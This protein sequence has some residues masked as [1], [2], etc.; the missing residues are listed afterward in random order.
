MPPLRGTSRS[1]PV[2][3]GWGTHTP[4]RDHGAVTQPGCCCSRCRGNSRREL[5][6]H[7]QKKPFRWWP[8]DA[9]VPAPAS[10]WD[11]NRGR[12]EW[13]PAAGRPG[14]RPS[15]ADQHLVDRVAEGVV[16]V[17][18]LVLLI[19]DEEARSAVHT[20]PDTAHEILAHPRL[21]GVVREGIDDDG[22]GNA[23]V[24]GVAAEIVVAQ[25]TLVGEDRLMHRPELPRRARRFGGLGS[26]LGVRVDLREREVPEHEAHAVPEVALQR[27]DDR[28]GS[29]AVG[30]LVVAILDE[31]D[32]GVSRAAGVVAVGDRGGE[33]A[34]RASSPDA[35]WSGRR[36]SRGT[37]ADG[38]GT[39]GPWAA[40]PARARA[41]SRDVSRDAPGDPS[42]SRAA[43]MPS[44]PGLTPIGERWLQRITPSPS[45]TK[46]ARSS[47]PSAALYTPYMRATAPLGSKSAR[48]GKC[49]WR[50]AANAAW[51]H[52]PS[53]E[54][55]TS[56]ARCR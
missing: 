21:E 51:H 50:A 43:R 26:T 9:A 16:L 34:H 13:R 17:R 23:G 14:G 7:H 33:R 6:L 29:A 45:T 41:G 4:A 12:H 8:R 24:G 20:A 5:P 22:A 49:K 3:G 19:V 52:A 35:P 39:A 32:R 36:G 27:L 48:S 37:L 31:R 54:T 47:S 55:P 40:D 56:S 1:P 44:A 18:A 42:D 30:T 10:V 25:R 2:V 28:L 11:A 15:T 53:T 38:A 46:S